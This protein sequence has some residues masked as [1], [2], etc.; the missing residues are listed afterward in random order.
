MD[1]GRCLAVYS[2]SSEVAKSGL[3]TGEYADAWAARLGHDSQAGVF[4]GASNFYSYVARR[5]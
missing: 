1:D 2:P 5:V 4:F 3:M